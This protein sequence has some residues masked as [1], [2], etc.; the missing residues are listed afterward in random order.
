MPI[1]LPLVRKS[2]RQKLGG[3][4]SHDTANLDYKK[5]VGRTALMLSCL[6][7][8]DVWALNIAQCLLERGASIVDTKDSNG[9]NA[10]MYAVIY[11]RVRLLEVFL[12]LVGDYGL[13][14]K[15]RFGNNVFHLAALGSNEAICEQLHKSFAKY[16]NHPMVNQS[17]NKKGHT[18][19][20]LCRSNGHDRCLSTIYQVYHLKLSKETPE[21]SYYSAQ[22]PSVLTHVHFNQSLEQMTESHRGIEQANA[23]VKELN[24]SSKQVI[25]ENE[26]SSSYMSEVATGEA[27]ESNYI[28]VASITNGIAPLRVD[29]PDYSYG[30][31]MKNC[32]VPKAYKYL[33]VIKE[34]LIKHSEM[35]VDTYHEI[36]SKNANTYKNNLANYQKIMEGNNHKEFEP[37][38]R[39]SIVFQSIESNMSKSFR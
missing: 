39:Y 6:I 13:L 15:D 25:N 24:S 12:N 30:M 35:Y 28:S 21:T 16:R 20:Y 22:K 1:V 8:D 38:Y 29:S 3:A 26:H 14:N 9:H 23:G 37:H 34:Q 27:V 2:S 7:E 4:S 32:D 19:F 31:D 11:Q 5:T 10:L 36:V 17:K 33:S 18:P